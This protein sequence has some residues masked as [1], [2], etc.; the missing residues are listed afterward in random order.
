MNYHLKKRNS[1]E[2]VAVS[3]IELGIKSIQ[4]GTR[5]GDEVGSNLEFFFDK[6]K[7]VNKALY[8]DLFTKYCIVRIDSDKKEIKEI[9]S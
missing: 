3:K 4:N 6:L 5:R 9:H 7:E 2:S 8:E 1:I